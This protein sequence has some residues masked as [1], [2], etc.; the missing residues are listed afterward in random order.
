LV[1]NMSR[2]L[3][4]GTVVSDKMEKT[5]VV[6]I[7]SRKPHPLYRKLLKRRKRLKV[8]NTRGAKI[9]DRVKVKESRPLSKTKRF[10]VVEIIKR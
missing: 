7:E 8:E 1:T 5:V 6:E 9:K 2:K 10:K 4:V 3:L